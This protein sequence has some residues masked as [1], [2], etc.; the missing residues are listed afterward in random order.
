VLEALEE[1]TTKVFCRRT[2][3]I[4][5]HFVH[6][7]EITKEEIDSRSSPWRIHEVPEAV[8]Y[9]IGAR[10]LQKHSSSVKLGRNRSLDHL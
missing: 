6:L 7:T 4:R 3:P 2:S 9:F 5:E 8:R 10:R 1:G